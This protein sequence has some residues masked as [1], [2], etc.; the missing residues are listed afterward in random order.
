[1]LCK[2]PTV[3]SQ[4]PSC[5]TTSSKPTRRIAIRGKI[6]NACPGSRPMKPCA[7][8]ETMD[9]PEVKLVDALL[10]QGK[11]K[12]R[13]RQLPTNSR[14]LLLLDYWQQSR[15]Y[16]PTRWLGIHC[17]SHYYFE[18]CETLFFILLATLSMKPVWRKETEWNTVIRTRSYSLTI[19]KKHSSKSVHSCSSSKVCPT[20]ITCDAHTEYSYIHCPTLAWKQELNHKNQT[21]A[22]WIAFSQYLATRWALSRKSW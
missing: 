20:A 16:L 14:L 21:Q 13:K 19:K 7:C 17:T 5:F 11:R 18:M 8:T 2:H 4:T 3:L 15:D 12:R 10:K 6:Q 22:T 1:M 9:K